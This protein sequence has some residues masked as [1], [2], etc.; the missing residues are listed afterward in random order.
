MADGI[1]LEGARLAARALVTAVREP[2]ACFGEVARRFEDDGR[3]DGEELF[4]H[5]STYA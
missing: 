5:S 4:Q 2:V 1:A 3:N